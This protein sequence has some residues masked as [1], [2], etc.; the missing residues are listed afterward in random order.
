MPTP[1]R[2]R[3]FS[4]V[5]ALSVAAT[6]TACGSSSSSTAKSGG[7]TDAGR[8]SVGIGYFQG[9]VSGPESVIAANTE[10]SSKVAGN[11]KLTPIN[12]GVAGLAELRGGSFPFVSGVGNPPVVGSIANGTKLKVIYAE[13]LDAAELV[14]GPDI[15]TNA[16]LAGKKIADLTGSSEDFEIRGWLKTQ[17][18]DDKV[19]VVGF[20]SEA[21]AAAAYKS[22]AVAG[23]Y[24]ELDQAL[25]L[26]SQGGRKVVDAQEIAQLGYPS[27]N[28]LAVTDDFAS[29]HKAVVQDLVCQ[30]IH[31]EAI[32][33]QPGTAA[34]PYIEK[35]AAL[36]GAKVDLAKVATKLIP[37]IKADDELSWFH[38]ANG[39]TS[40]GKIAKAYALTGQFLLEQGRVTK[41]PTSDQISAALDSSYVEKALADKCGTV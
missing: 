2:T 38:D 36:V 12:S 21:A 4:A 18:L 9:A 30:A 11:L 8:P 1:S 3:G 26:L 31:A 19:K 20:A 14:V 37:W 29:K 34:D 23:S 33:T 7:S 5:I 39:S 22:K 28:V 13:Y 25:D 32:V 35:S 27:L 6:L 16:D 15:K 24:V 10:L 40:E 17:K 41:V